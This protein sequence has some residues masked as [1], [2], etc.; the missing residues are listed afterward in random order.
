M[1]LRKIEEITCRR[2]N[3]EAQ[4]REQWRDVTQY[5]QTWDR[6]GSQFASWTCGSYYD[7]MWVILGPK[8]LNETDRKY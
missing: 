2:R 7:H 6:V 1:S 8:F 5:F 4:K 3:E